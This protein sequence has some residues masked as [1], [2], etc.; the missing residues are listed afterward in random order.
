MNRTIYSTILMLVICSV[1]SAPF[2]HADPVCGKDA[3][4]VTNTQASEAYENEDYSWKIPVSGGIPPYTCNATGTIPSWLHINASAFS[5]IGKPPKGLTADSVSVSLR[6]SDSAVPPSTIDATIIIPLRYKSTISFKP[7]ISD[8]LIVIY[9]DGQQTDKFTNSSSTMKVFP[10][11]SKHVISVDQAIQDANNTV[12]Y[13][14]DIT[15]ISVSGISPDAAFEY[16]PEY[17]IKVKSNIPDLPA[18][19]GSGWYKQGSVVNS[20]ALSSYDS[21]NGTQYRFAFWKLPTGE[22]SGNQ[23]LNLTVTKQGEAVATYDTYYQ[24]AFNTEHCT[25]N[26]GGWY[27]AG[28]SVR[29]NVV[30]SDSVPVA[31]FWGALGVEMKPD[32]AAGT[33]VMDGPR[34][35]TITW[36]PY[37]NKIIFQIV[38]AIVGAI[39]CIVIGLLHQR[40]K[41]LI[42]RLTNRK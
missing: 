29:W 40:I 34:I 4:I 5:L 37:Y 41:I 33:A 18:L 38:F 21:T 14:T 10:S 39:I 24:L 9:V 22:V 17:N 7:A 32:V 8:A 19:S 20:S 13:S 12:R 28:S 30:C 26:G 16:A 42:T 3:P 27:K 6:I 36:N 2:V 15:K 35:I 11:S 25:V 23:N 1:F 31:G